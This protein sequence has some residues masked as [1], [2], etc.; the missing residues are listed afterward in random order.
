MVDTLH[1]D[2]RGLENWLSEPLA[3]TRDLLRRMPGDVVVL[4]AGGK[5]RPTLATEAFWTNWQ[6]RRTGERGSTSSRCPC[7]SASAQRRTCGNC[8]VRDGQSCCGRWPRTQTPAARGM[9]P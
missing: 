5:M 9:C 4:G 1:I 7:A 6:S 3:A 2:E 8:H